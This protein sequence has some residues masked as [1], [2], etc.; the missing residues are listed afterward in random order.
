MFTKSL[1]DLDKIQVQVQEFRGR[2][3][4]FCLF[5]KVPGGA[6]AADT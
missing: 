1:G 5:N 3:L 6:N 4:R 2:G